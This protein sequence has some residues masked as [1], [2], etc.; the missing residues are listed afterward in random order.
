MGEIIGFHQ[1]NQKT[2]HLLHLFYSDNTMCRADH[3]SALLLVGAKVL[4][5]AVPCLD[6]VGKYIES[7][8]KS[9]RL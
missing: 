6:S 2:L 9:N 1:T 7:F 8:Y 5:L 4:E 3:Q